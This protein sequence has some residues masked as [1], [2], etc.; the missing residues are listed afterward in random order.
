MWR[1]LG[2]QKRF[3]KWRLGISEVLTRSNLKH[4]SMLGKDG[5]WLTSLKRNKLKSKKC[6]CLNSRN[7]KKLRK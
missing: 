6:S 3:R 4:K 5:V 1:S 2:I 7:R